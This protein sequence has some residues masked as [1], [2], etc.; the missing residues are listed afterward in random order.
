LVNAIAHAVLPF[1]NKPYAIFG[2]SMGALVAFELSQLLSSEYN[3]TPLDLFVAARHAPQIPNP[4]L[5]IYNLPEAEFIQ[6]LRSFDATP[7][8]VLENRELMELFLPIIRADFAVLDTYRYTSDRTL[9]CPITVFGGLQDQK[10]SYAD[11][12]A[13]KTQTSNT[14]SLQMVDGNHFFIHSALEI[15]LKTIAKK[16][17][18]R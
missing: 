10:V 6:E 8:A 3:L 5:P 13:W 16:L 12:T 18:V 9:N 4:K 1:L 2:Y 14:F 17:T 15:L 11:L 7:D